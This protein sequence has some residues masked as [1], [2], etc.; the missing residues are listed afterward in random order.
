MKNTVVKAYIFWKKEQ[1][2]TMRVKASAKVDGETVQAD[3][4]KGKTTADIF[5]SGEKALIFLYG[6]RA[7][8]TL[9]ML[10]YKRFWEKVISSIRS[11]QCQEVEDVY[12]VFKN[13]NKDRRA[14]GKKSQIWDNKEAWENN[15]QQ[16]LLCSP[17]TYKKLENCA[18]SK[19]CVQLRQNKNYVQIPLNPQS[20]EDVLV[21]SWYMYLPRKK[22]G[23]GYEKKE[24]KCR[25]RRKKKQTMIHIMNNINLPAIAVKS[26]M[27]YRDA[28][29]TFAVPVK[30]IANY[31]S[32]RSI[33][34]V[35]AGRKV[36]IL[37]DSK[38]IKAEA[39]KR[40]IESAKCGFPMT[41]KQV[42]QSISWV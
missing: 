12:F 32:N 42:Q 20:I 28:N 38:E 31:T 10:R 39:V 14:H 19:Y 13:E 41:R 34:G 37:N 6:A 7:D 18:Q 15:N 25:R 36:S 22:N 29:K 30:T 2:V 9:N 11:V 21:L 3:P 26:G 27:S 40:V 23:A 17:T 4:T 5:A 24:K 33:V 8:D 35:K 16:E 1:I